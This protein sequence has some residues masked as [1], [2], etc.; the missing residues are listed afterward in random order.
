MPDLLLLDAGN[1]CLKWALSHDNVLS[2]VRRVTY[3]ENL[4]FADQWGAMPA[5]QRILMVNVAGEDIAQNLRHWFR[6]HWQ[7]PLEMVTA[8]ARACGVSNCYAEPGRLGGDRWAAMIAAHHRFRG[9]VCV[10]D[11]GT[12]TTLDVVSAEGRH[13]G[14]LIVPGLELMQSALVDNTVAIAGRVERED[15]GLLACSTL[16]AVGA[17]SLHASVGFIEHVRARL[18]GLLEG[19]LTSVICGGNAADLLPWLPAEIHHEPDLVLQ[20]LNIIAMKRA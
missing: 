3:S 16:A 14:G 6:L 8:T 15:D 20:G 13:L 10:I 4:D 7:L 1:S 17:G 19:P 2:P 11:C 9:A 18:A 5:P 12:A